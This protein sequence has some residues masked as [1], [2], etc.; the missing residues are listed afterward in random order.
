MGYGGLKLDVCSMKCECFSFRPA[1][2][3]GTSRL[4]E[5]LCT[6]VFPQGS[7][8]HLEVWLVASITGSTALDRR[9]TLAAH[10]HPSAL[11]SEALL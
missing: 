4:A 10:G 5:T 11:L 1:L 8:E 2:P 6:Y 7:H 9:Q 3:H